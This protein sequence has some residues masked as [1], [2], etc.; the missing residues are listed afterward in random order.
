MNALSRYGMPV[1]LVVM[2]LIVVLSA[3][4]INFIKVRQ[5][6]NPSINPS[7]FTSVVSNKYFSLSPG[8]TYVYQGNDGER[9][10]VFV[11]NQTK[12]TMGVTT[13]VVWD[14]EWKNDEL[15]E[16]TQDWFA[17]DKFGNVWYFGEDTKE[18]ENGVIVSTKGSWEAGV[19]GALP[20][21][22]MKANP[23]V[24]DLYRQEYYK[25]QAEDIAQVVAV[26]I[27]LNTSLGL[28][29]DCLETREWSLLDADSFE[30]KIYCSQVS[31]L[32]YEVD[33]SDGGGAQLIQIK[34]AFIP[35]IPRKTQS[36]VEQVQKRE[37]TQEQA[38]AIAIDTIGGVVRNVEL[39]R[40]F[41]T[42]AFVVEVLVD[43][44]EIDVI[45][46]RESGDVLGIER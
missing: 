22:V 16:D 45:I 21:I 8:I 4:V 27:Q 7:D 34:Q 35:Q 11:T 17:Q 26:G 39:E 6:Y 3:A 12:V 29:S 9:F 33:E 23:R 24:G 19:D 2:V 1:L 38:R 41:N 36:I 20:G 40:K 30:V 28:F 10:E 42:L 44:D 37:I 14:R 43:G 32:V 13:R 46:D 18:L 15:V 5:V 31:T 25:G